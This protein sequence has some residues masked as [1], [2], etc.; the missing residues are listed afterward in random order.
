MAEKG[1]CLHH[2]RRPPK[3]KPVKLTECCGRHEMLCT[4]KGKP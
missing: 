4:C 1:K 3:E 2:H